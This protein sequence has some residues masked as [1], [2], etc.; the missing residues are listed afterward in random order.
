MNFIL[1]M[2]NRDIHDSLLAESPERGVAPP[3]V[4]GF[5]YGFTYKIYKHNLYCTWVSFAYSR[6]LFVCLTA[7]GGLPI[8]NFLTASRILESSHDNVS[9]VESMTEDVICD[10]TRGTLT[11][12]L[13]VHHHLL[14]RRLLKNEHLTF[15]NLH[16]QEYH[17]A[18]LQTQLVSCRFSI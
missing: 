6:F 8:Q 12:V 18:S 14:T 2:A 4:Y 11:Y 10:V 15:Q 9:W 3:S 5:A 17:G 13:L 1:K 16:Q 7:F